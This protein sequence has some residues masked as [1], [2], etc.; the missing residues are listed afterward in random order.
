VLGNSLK[1]VLTEWPVSQ[2]RQ[3]SILLYKLGGKTQI[4]VD[5][6]LF[7]SIVRNIE[8]NKK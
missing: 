4:S 2:A 7:P 5:K 1:T 3:I 6:Y 8:G